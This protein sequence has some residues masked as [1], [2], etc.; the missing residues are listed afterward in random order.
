MR[1]KD[2]IHY[3]IDP[4]YRAMYTLNHHYHSFMKK[5]SS[6]RDFVRMFNRCHLSKMPSWISKKERS[7]YVEILSNRRFIEE[8]LGSKEY[9]YDYHGIVIDSWNEIKKMYDRMNSEMEAEMNVYEY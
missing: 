1:T 8:Y 7:T 2:L 4:Q 5:G 9:T 6:S 3:V